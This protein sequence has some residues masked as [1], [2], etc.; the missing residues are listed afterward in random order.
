MKI[1]STAQKKQS[2][3]QRMTRQG[4]GVAIVSKGGNP[5]LQAT[6]LREGA[7]W[8]I[9]SHPESEGVFKI[10]TIEF[11]DKWRIA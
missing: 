6:G 9:L 5:E 11:D 10:S 1:K 8:W 3:H 2:I 7:N 4:E